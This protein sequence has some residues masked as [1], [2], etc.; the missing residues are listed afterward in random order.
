MIFS[1]P[2][3]SDMSLTDEVIAIVLSVLQPGQ[4]SLVISMSP[5][6]LRKS[7]KSGAA[8]RQVK[9]NQSEG[10]LNLCYSV[11]QVFD[12]EIRQP[13]FSQLIEVPGFVE[14]GIVTEFQ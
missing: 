3:E 2:S 1:S 11:F 10:G 7:N 13:C 9:K 5:D 6:Q 8:C 12:E 4:N 14:N